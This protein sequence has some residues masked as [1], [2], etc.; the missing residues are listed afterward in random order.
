M[1]STTVQISTT[2]NTTAGAYNH[3]A[4]SIHGVAVKFNV[5]DSGNVVNVNNSYGQLSDQRMKENIVDASSQWDDIKSL[6]VRKFNFIGDNLTQIGVV[7]QEVEASGMNG[8][9]QEAKWFDAAANPDNEVRKSVKYSVLYMKAIKALQ[10][11]MT[12]IE[13]LETKVA[14]LE[15]K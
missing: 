14:A 8:L 9:I 13:T 10:E 1:S 3:L 11:A 12:R 15:A 7:A 2:R 5:F 4:C 6:Q